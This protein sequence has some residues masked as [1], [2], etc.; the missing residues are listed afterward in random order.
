VLFELSNKALSS[1]KNRKVIIL[2]SDAGII[3]AILT[4][5]I[6]EIESKVLYNTSIFIK[7]IKELFFY[8]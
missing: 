8:N 2:K 4:Q 3:L 1:Y 7:D 5:L 6:L